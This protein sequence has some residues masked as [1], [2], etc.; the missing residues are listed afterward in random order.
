KSM[1]EAKVTRLEGT[2]LVWVDI[3]VT[4]LTSDEMTAHLLREHHI[5]VNSG[6]MYGEAGEGFIRINIACPRERILRAPF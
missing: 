6:T 5:L 1:P 3:R 4:G 2:Y